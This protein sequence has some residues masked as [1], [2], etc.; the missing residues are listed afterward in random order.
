MKHSPVFLSSR[1]S[2]NTSTLFDLNNLLEAF[3]ILRQALQDP[4]APVPSVRCQD[5]LPLPGLKIRDPASLFRLTVQQHGSPRPRCD[6]P[7]HHLV[8]HKKCEGPG[9]GYTN[10]NDNFWVCVHCV[11]R[12]WERYGLEVNPIC[13][14]LC[15]R[16]SRNY[17]TEN[18]VSALNQC[19][20]QWEQQD[21]K[22]HLCTDCRITRSTADHR[23]DVRR[24]IGYNSHMVP[25][26]LDRLWRI[27]WVH[28]HF[29]RV[30]LT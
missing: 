8:Q 4:R 10:H 27:S 21:A 25:H 5:R 19:R 18:P 7:G 1:R 6:I 11:R 2:I 20:C 22:L 16:C 30:W 14:D 17:R 29:P 12:A 3:P 28:N 24:L 26:A 13:Y 15:L 23:Q 9:L